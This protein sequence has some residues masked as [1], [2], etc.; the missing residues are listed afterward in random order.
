MKS[1]IKKIF[2]NIILF[3]SFITVVSGVAVLFTV[4]Q[5]NSYKKIDIL[6]EQK[7][8]ISTLKKIDKKDVEIALIQFNGKSTELLYQTQKLH[9]LHEYDFVGTYILKTSD[10]YTSQLNTLTELI[11]TYNS[12]AYAYYKSSNNNNNNTAVVF[13]NAYKNINNHISNIIF[14]NITYDKTKL[15]FMYDL[16]L[17]IFVLILLFSLI[18][19]KKLKRISA[20][21]AFLQSPSANHEKYEIYSI[22]ADAIFLKMNRKPTISQNSSNIDPV[23]GI[24]NNKGLANAY[25]EKKGLKENNFTALTIIE[26]DNFSKTNKTF[27]QDFT[28]NILKKIASIISMYEQATDVIARSDYNEFTVILSRPNAKKALEEI[29]QIRQSIEEL[30]FTTPNREP[31]TITISGGFYIK[32]HNISLTNAIQEAKSILEYAKQNGG[33]RISQKK[34]IS[35]VKI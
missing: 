23:T 21:L 18:F 12:S 2:N 13:S 10:E 26:V 1:S 28:Q 11:N 19:Y 27:P 15:N 4:E 3:L 29:E 7:Q 14:K 6:N 8:I 31:V 33:N 25:S 17:G 5:N 20:D 22:E 16:A 35:G 24:N 32:P 9:A 34:D 30:N